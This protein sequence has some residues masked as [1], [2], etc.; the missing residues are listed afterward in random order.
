MISHVSARHGI[1]Q[2]FANT[3]TPSENGVVERKNR[4][5]L[6]MAR[7][8]LA[9]RSLPPSLWVEAV[10]TAV[11]VLNRSPTQAVPHRTPFEVYFSQKPD[12]S[13][14]KVFGCDAYV[15]V[16]KGQRMKLDPSQRNTLLW[17]TI[18]S[19]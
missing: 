18:L 10:S 17:G 11:H 6:E 7:S 5:V 3:G 14:F 2:E 15:H 1:R 13:Y 9:H 16:P 4:I 19:P 8:M 12:V